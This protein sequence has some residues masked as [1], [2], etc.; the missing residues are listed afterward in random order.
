MHMI[1]APLASAALVGLRA[2]IPHM[3][4]NIFNQDPT[5]NPADAY[6]PDLAAEQLGFPRSFDS[7][8]DAAIQGVCAAFAAGVD[9]VEVDF[10]PIAGVNA[11]GDGSAKSEEAIADANAA[12]VKKCVDSL[13]AMEDNGAG[14]VA[15]VGCGSRTTR[16]LGSGAVPLRD[17]ER[18]AAGSDVAICVAP[19]DVEQWEAAAALGSRCVV[20][21]NGLL[22]NGRHQHA[23]YY[24]PLTAFSAQTGGCV[25]QY[26][27]PYIIY[28]VEGNRL[29]DIDVPLSR[30]GRRALPDTK[31]AQ[32]ALQNSFGRAT[33]GGGARRAG[34]TKM[35]LASDT[36]TLSTRA[37]LPSGVTPE[38]LHDFLAT[39]SNW[40]RIVLSSQRVEG[41]GIE[42]PL[43]VGSTVDEIFGLPP[44]IPLSVRWT[45]VASDRAGGRLEFASPGGLDG[46]ASECKMAFDISASGVL[47]EMSYLPRSPLARLA[48][49]VLALD[50]ALALKLLLPRALADR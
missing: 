18:A 44:L 27:G 7:I 31:Q 50:N 46:V 32:M 28:D 9:V 34:D 47:L 38:A 36:V 33:G 42:R 4:F 5:P 40:P 19:A 3:F 41:D 10:P 23:Y 17:G 49:P 25:R 1:V 12:F 21:V 14:R 37:S 39:P 48:T 30:Q 2:G 15:V 45:C 22:N 43:G 35:L 6:E 24:K 26:P 8:H 29:D 13:T 16:A 11:R 20:I